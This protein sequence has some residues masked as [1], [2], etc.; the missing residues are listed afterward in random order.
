MKNMGISLIKLKDHVSEIISGKMD[1]HWVFQDIDFSE[2]V[3][4]KYVWTL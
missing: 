3:D 1:I 2:P 4:E